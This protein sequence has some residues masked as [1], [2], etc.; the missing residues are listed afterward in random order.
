MSF[1]T[2]RDTFVLRVV[3]YPQEAIIHNFEDASAYYGK[4]VEPAEESK[5]GVADKVDDCQGEF[6]DSVQGL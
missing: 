6:P 4:R 3:W 1:P 2:G 5:V